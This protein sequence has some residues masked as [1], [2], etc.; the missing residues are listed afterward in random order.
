MFMLLLCLRS[1]VVPRRIIQNS[2]VC[3]YNLFILCTTA[4]QDASKELSESTYLARVEYA[5]K[6]FLG[7]VFRVYI[8]VH[9]VFV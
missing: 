4:V 2:S 6:K 8:Y 9:V 3:L 5:F 7:Y 1:S